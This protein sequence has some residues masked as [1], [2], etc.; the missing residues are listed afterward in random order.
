[1]IRAPEPDWPAPGPAPVATVRL[2]HRIGENRGV[3]SRGAVAHS[4]WVR[5]S[6]GMSGSPGCPVDRGAAISR[7]EQGP[8][9]APSGPVL[10]EDGRGELE[11]LRGEVAALRAAL[12]PRRARIRW[13][14]PSSLSWGGWASS[15]ARSSGAWAPPIGDGA[16]RSWPSPCRAWFSLFWRCGCVIIEAFRSRRGGREAAAMLLREH[17]LSVRWSGVRSCSSYRRRPAHG[18]ATARP[19]RPAR[20]RVY[21]AHRAR[22]TDRPRMR[23]HGRGSGRPPS[24]RRALGR[25]GG[26]PPA[27]SRDRKHGLTSVTTSTRGLAIGGCDCHSV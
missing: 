21:P 22:G 27:R 9:R 3:L 15:P 17:R 26:P 23:S 8:H 6:R 18:S 14:P 4:L 16:R 1:M 25:P 10:D 7:S 13:P 20:R 24:P 12:A 19:A 5:P 11:R 2:R